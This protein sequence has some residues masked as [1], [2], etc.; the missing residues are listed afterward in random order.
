MIRLVKENY[1]FLLIGSTWGISQALVLA[2]G[3]S[4]IGA[5]V[6]GTAV[7]FYLVFP[8][9]AVFL[10]CASFIAGYT[11]TDLRYA[12]FGVLLSQAI[13]AVAILVLWIHFSPSIAQVSPAPPDGPVPQAIFASLGFA[14]IGFFLVSLVASVGG[15]ILGDRMEGQTRTRNILLTKYRI[16]L[17]TLILVTLIA[18]PT[19]ALQAQVDNLNRSLN[20]Q[21]GFRVVNT[22]LTWDTGTANISASFG[23][24]PEGAGILTISWGAS[25]PL[26]FYIIV[27]DITETATEGVGFRDIPFVNPPETAATH[28]FVAWFHNDACTSTSCPSGYV[29]YSI[30]IYY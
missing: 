17:L 7:G 5:Y 22:R 30:T 14:V 28:I 4:Q 15:V 29:D 20:L 16:V 11:L 19:L 12:V 25:E 2:Y 24:V 6:G 10:V 8:F 26:T 1:R 18:F 21:N 9:Y 13:S 27:L 3:I 23:P